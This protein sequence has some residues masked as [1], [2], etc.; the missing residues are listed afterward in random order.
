MSE[1]SPLVKPYLKWAGGKRQLLFELEKYMP[2]D[3]AGY[4]YYEPFVGAGALFFYLQPKR[5]IIND[6][7]EELM[8]TYSVIKNDVD[9]LIAE[10]KEHRDKNSR[11]YFYEIR[12][13]D[14]NPVSFN[15]LSA[16]SRAARLI[17]LNKTCY[18]G[19]YR[20]NQ[21]GFF[22]VPYGSNKDPAIFEEATLKA[23]NKY[24]NAEEN[25][26]KITSGD[27]EKSVKGAGN[28]AFV[29]F[30]PPYYSPNSLS[31]T[32][33]QANKFSEFEQLRLRDTFKALTE[34]GAKCL[35]S[36]SDTKF[37][38]ELYSDP[39]YEIISVSAKRPINSCPAGRGS[40][41][42]VLIRNFR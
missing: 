42:E 2:K 14:K 18:N 20:V 15:G 37:I 7:N 6:Y 36:N 13:L 19:L 10:L 17:Y 3:I 24:L 30:D 23:I 9:A 34:R 5:A 39:E 32:D 27:F 28:A 41:G 33:Y 38:R 22:N 1:K 16:I 35:L 26:I 8:L 31:F 12:A 25:E 11:E 40:V 4:T 21:K 29:Y